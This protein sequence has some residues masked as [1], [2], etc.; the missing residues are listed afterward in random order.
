MDHRIESFIL[1]TS[2][3]HTRRAK[4]IYN[5]SMGLL[6]CDIKF[7]VYPAKDPKVPGETW[8]KYREGKK[9]V[10]FEYVKLT[11]YYLADFLWGKSL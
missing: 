7:L 10:F 8:W 2:P 5:D 1:V 4:L 6:G 11:A 9:I 3:Y